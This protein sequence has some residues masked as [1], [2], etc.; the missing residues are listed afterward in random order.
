MQADCVGEVS[1]RWRGVHSGNVEGEPLEMLKTED[2]E[3]SLSPRS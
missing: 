1:N 3:V 2:L